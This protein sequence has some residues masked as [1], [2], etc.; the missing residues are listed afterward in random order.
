MFADV[1]SMIHFYGQ[2]LFG[3][4]W[5]LIWTVIL[6]HVILLPLMGLVAYLTFWERKVVGWM[7]TRMGPNRT[8][9][10]GLLQP[11]AD[12]LKLLLKEIIIPDKADKWLFY[13]AP[14]LTMTPALVAW[15]VVPFGADM[16]LSDINA[17]LLFFMTITGIG[18]YGTIIAGWASN[19]KYSFLG[20]M[21]A[22]AQMIS[23]GVPMSFILVTIILVSGS[24][25]LSDIVMMQNKGFFA[26]LGI[27]LLSW[28]F[29]PLFPLFIIFIICS[30][31]ETGRHPFDVIE[32]ESEIVGGHMVEYSG[33]AF[34]MFFLA[35]Y[36]NMILFSAMASIFF[37][38]GWTAPVS[39]EFLNWIPGWIWLGGKTF[40]VVNLFILVRATFPRYRYDHAMRLGWKVFLP[41]TLVY[42]VLVAIWIK[43]PF[44][45]WL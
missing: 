24:L 35:E 41:I 38:G 26:S 10:L 18:I 32:G 4:W 11:I 27:P 42:L 3:N 21:R 36:A 7:H 13:L 2:S 6:I 45:I 31:A 16:A 44:N 23:F 22:A 33:I 39:W 28:N 19:S 37:L 9:P 29:I 8:G 40:V 14:V 25:N 34:G 5:Y 15:A 1:L 20:A 12:G 17:G 43:T 30:F